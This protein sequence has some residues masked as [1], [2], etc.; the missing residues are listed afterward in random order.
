MATIRIDRRAALVWID[1]RV[2]ELTPTEWVIFEYLFDHKHE[3]IPAKWVDHLKGKH[4][5]TWHIHNIRV[6]IDP[7]KIVLRR[8]WGYRL[9]DYDEAIDAT[10]EA[11]TL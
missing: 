1:D 8:S 2:V 5:A 6:K 9:A 10:P 3:Y 11:V 4:Q 7:A